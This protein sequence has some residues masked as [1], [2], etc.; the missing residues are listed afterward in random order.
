MWVFFIGAV[1]IYTS[2]N[3]I[4]RYKKFVYLIASLVI[5]EGLIVLFQNLGII[6]FLWN[7]EYALSY[8]GFLSG[9]LGPN[10]I[11]L[12]MTML[13]SLAFLMSAVFI[14]PLKIFRPYIYSAIGIAAIVILITGSRTTY[15]AGIIF[16]VYFF[17]R[18]MGRAFQ[19]SIYT[20]IGFF[21]L[22]YTNPQ[23][24]ELIDDTIKGRITNK[25][26]GPGDVNTVEDFTGIYD[27]LG[28]GRNY[29]HKQYV[30]YLA[31][32]PYIIPFGIGLNNRL[33]IGFSAHNQYLSLINEVGLVGL[34]FF[35]TWLLS[36]LTIVKGKLPSIRASLN[37]LVFAMIVSLY[38]GEHL[39]IYRPLFALLGLF[40]LMAALIVKPLTFLK[41]E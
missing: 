14:K 36:Y 6:P 22:T 37:G 33:L 26:T 25:I 34:Y 17:L 28:S 41:K 32:R 31:E 15:V 40:L 10:K 39:Y 35:M 24:I 16:L 9:T 4:K 5:L 29:L 11:V 20:L 1:L 27:D 18:N 30:I 7:R 8:D 23:I 21:I 3:T 38:F 19:I 2:V 13:I 12:G